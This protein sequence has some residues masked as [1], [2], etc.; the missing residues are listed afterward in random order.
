MTTKRR[1]AAF[2]AVIAA[3][4]LTLSACGGDSEEPESD[5]TEDAGAED[6]GSASGTITVASDAEFTSYNGN[7]V[8]GN[9][10]W[11]TRVLNGV[12][13]GFWDYAP[14]GGSVPTEEF[15]TYELTSEDPLTVQYTFAEDAV[16]SDGEPIDCD[17]FLL[18]WAANSGYYEH[19]TE[20]TEDGSPAQ[21]F[22][23]PSSTGL[24]LTQKPSCEAGAK[25]VELVYDEPFADWPVAMSGGTSTLPAHVAADQ[26]GL[27]SEELIAA[28]ANDDIDTLLPV[29]EF[30]STGWDMNPGDLLDPALIPASGPYVIDSWDAGQS[31]TLKANENWWGEPPATDTIVVRF[32][33][34]DQQVQA[35][36]NGEVD[37]IS[38]QASVDLANSLEALGD[39]VE[40]INGD[41]LTWEHFDFNVN[42]GTVFESAEL[43]EAFAKCLPR[44]QIVDNLIKPVNPEAVVMDLRELFPFD[45]DYETVREAAIG[46][47]Y[48]EPDIAGATDL[49]EQSG[50]ETPVDVRILRS[51]PNPR[52]AD[53]V[54]LAKAS[55]D[56]AGFNIVDTP[57]QDLGAG[58][59]DT[60]SYDIA[61]FGW[62]GSGLLTSGASLYKTN[63][64]QNQYGYSNSDVDAAWDKLVVELDEAA[65]VELLTE[66]ETNL[67][68]DL[69][70]IPVFAHP[71]ITAHSPRVEGVM[72]NSAQTQVSF[73]ME[74]W[75]LT[76]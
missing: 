37:V 66:I 19:P 48:A 31:I 53:Q 46:D 18:E 59:V 5:S 15:G 64:G 34:Q 16:W 58:I 20:T 6:T 23:S 7:S 26:A 74:E 72:H 12:M 28:I 50:V 51:D 14:E 43:R 47:T 1:G 75:A 56:E 3:G 65:Q 42:P 41:N 55:C 40:V 22:A 57:T 21:L 24:N 76:E 69:F 4:A 35:L 73:N 32:M 44:Q 60:G 11:N 2:L 39:Q 29:A 17:D 38:P 71:G 13:T 68:D 49:I 36:A 9:G 70:S 52:R 67:W 63:E 45:P 33:A 25:E 30:W 10:T 27:S 54:A 8:T 61:M 62:A